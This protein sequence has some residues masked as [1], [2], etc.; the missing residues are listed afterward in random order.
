MLID[1]MQKARLY[2][3]L[4]EPLF[5][6]AAA[7]LIRQRHIGHVTA[8]DIMDHGIIHVFTGACQDIDFMSGPGAFSHQIQIDGGFFE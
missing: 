2:E 6:F 7:E 8:V 3:E 5:Y 1:H 4:D